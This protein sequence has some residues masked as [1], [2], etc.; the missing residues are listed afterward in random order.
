MAPPEGQAAPQEKQG[1]HLKAP[2]KN[3][4]SATTVGAAG[5]YLPLITGHGQSLS[6]KF[7]N[8]QGYLCANDYSISSFFF[9]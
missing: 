7:L 4:I 1:L 3:A 2:Y 8:L 5:Q 9:L 6:L